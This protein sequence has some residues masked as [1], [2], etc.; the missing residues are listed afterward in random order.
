MKRAYGTEPPSAAAVEL[1]GK[2]TALIVE[3]AVTFKDAM[4][5]LDAA[6]EKLEKETRPVRAERIH[7]GR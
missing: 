2:I 4:D 7:E 3:S 5:A 6:E 1:A